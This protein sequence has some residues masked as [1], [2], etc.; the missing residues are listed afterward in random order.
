MHIHDMNGILKEIKNQA[1]ATG[2]GC[3]L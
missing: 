2:I 3:K 1:D